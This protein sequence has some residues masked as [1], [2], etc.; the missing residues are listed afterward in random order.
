VTGHGTNEPHHTSPP[1]RPAARYVVA[2]RDGFDWLVR[3]SPKGD[4]WI[5]AYVDLD[6]ALNCAA[7]LNLHVQWEAP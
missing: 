3:T 7:M 6:T 4:I 1:L 2:P 5:S